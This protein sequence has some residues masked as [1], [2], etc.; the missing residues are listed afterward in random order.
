MITVGVWLQ[1]RLIRGFQVLFLFPPLISL[2][3]ARH[4]L[5]W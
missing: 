5:L 1:A 3:G 4:Y 2:N